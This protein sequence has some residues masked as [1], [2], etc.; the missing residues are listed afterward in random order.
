[1]IRLRAGRQPFSD[2]IVNPRS[3]EGQPVSAKYPTLA[4]VIPYAP[5][6]IICAF[7][8]TD[9]ID[10]SLRT[11]SSHGVTRHVIKPKFRATLNPSCQ[12]FAVRRNRSGGRLA[13][14]EQRA[15]IAYHEA[16]T[17]GR[18]DLHDVGFRRSR[19]PVHLG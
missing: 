2:R 19:Q 6:Y 10:H 8:L 1:M 13:F 11:A 4:F 3:S 7:I 9:F 5:M 18:G 15:I 17:P 12:Y 16:F 14:E